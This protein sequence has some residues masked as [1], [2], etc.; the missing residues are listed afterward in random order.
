LKALHSGCCPY[1]LGFC[2]MKLNTGINAITLLGNRH[3]DGRSILVKPNLFARR[4]AHA[5]EMF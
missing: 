3:S 1:Q 4:S 5:A 2:G